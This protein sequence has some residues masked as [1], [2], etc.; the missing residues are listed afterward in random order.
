VREGARHTILVPAEGVWVVDDEDRD[1]NDEVVTSLIDLQSKLRGDGDGDGEGPDARGAEPTDV[2]EIPE[3]GE[4]DVAVLVT[5]DPEDAAEHDEFAPVTTLP[6]AG[7]P[8][9]KLVA[10]AD[11]L[12]RIEREVAQLTTRGEPTGDRRTD[13]VVAL[14]QRLLHEVGSQ[15]AQLLREIHERFDRIEH[16]IA[17]ALSDAMRG[18]AS[19]RDEPEDDEPA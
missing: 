11:R 8:E 13:G 19:E 10:L 16:A 14:G 1:G 12:S 5:P 2:V 6:I 9:P 3:A 18:D 4:E 15:R 7:A 17:E